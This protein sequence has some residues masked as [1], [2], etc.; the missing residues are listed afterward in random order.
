[1]ARVVIMSSALPSLPSKP[2]SLFLPRL[3]TWQIKSK[4]TVHAQYICST[5]VYQKV[6]AASLYDLHKHCVEVTGDPLVTTNANTY[7]IILVT[8][9]NWTADYLCYWQLCLLKYGTKG[10]AHTH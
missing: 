5:A 4:R 8:S 1:M 3:M 7:Y 10:Y 2:G 9:S 6:H